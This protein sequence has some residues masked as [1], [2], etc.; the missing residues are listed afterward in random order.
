MAGNDNSAVFHPA[1]GN[2]PSPLIT[3]GGTR[4]FGEGGSSLSADSAFVVGP[5]ASLFV[6]GI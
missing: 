1:R 3:M 6:T 4:G 2:L 5:S